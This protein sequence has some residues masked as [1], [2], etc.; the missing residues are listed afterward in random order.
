LSALALAAQ[1]QFDYD[2]S[3]PLNARVIGVVDTAPFR[4]E[5]IVFDGGAG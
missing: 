4:R 2:R 5:K 1:G 3:A